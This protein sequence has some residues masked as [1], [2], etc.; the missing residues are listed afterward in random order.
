MDLTRV[1]TELCAVSAPSGAEQELADLLEQRWSDRC[2]QVRRDPVGNVIARVGGSG[3]RLL[4]QAHMDQGGY[5]VRYVT[6]GGQL[7][8][9]TSQGDRRTGPERRHPV[10]QAVRVLTRDSSW[11][12]GIIVAA[13]GHVLTNAQRE[14]SLAFDDFWV[15][16]G[17]G[18][19]A[20]VS[21]AGVHVGSPVVFSAPLRV[22]G[23]LLVG[24]AL[25]NRVGLAVMDALIETDGLARELWVGGAPPGGDGRARAGGAPPGRGV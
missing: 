15:E 5:V 4:V 17:L 3:P 7:L 22:L 13:S 16:L 6:E 23:E 25:D 18:S 9:D 8:L 19:R 2:A 20:A 10:G 24:P 12:E 1:L 11:A 21:A 14:S